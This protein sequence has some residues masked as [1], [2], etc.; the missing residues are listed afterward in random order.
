VTGIDLEID[1]LSCAYGKDAVLRDVTLPALQGGTMIAVLGPNGAGKSTLLKSI[2]GLMRYRG[3]I[4]IGGREISALGQ[5]EKLRSIGYSPQTA[6]QA[7]ALLA[8]EYAWSALRAALPELAP[9]EQE[10]RIRRAFERLGLSDQLFKQVGALSGGQRQRLGFSQVLAREPSLYL[11]DEP[12]SALDLRWEIE[13]LGL[14]RERADRD[15]AL[16][17]VALHDLNLATRFCDRFILLKDG[18]LLAEAP[19]MGGLTPEMIREAYGIDA[20][21]EA[22]SRGHPIIIADHTRNEETAPRRD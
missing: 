15:G 20:R 16:C 8:Y 17:L 6:P 5:A 11:L 1:A 10:T 3:S 2:A 18:A 9:A 12:T 22:C 4:R 21:I 13:A 7:S 19:V 14:M